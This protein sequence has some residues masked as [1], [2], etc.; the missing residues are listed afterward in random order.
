PYRSFKEP[1]KAYR[2]DVQVAHMRQYVTRND[3]AV[4]YINSGILTKA[5]YETAIRTSTDRAAE[6]WIAA[7]RKL[8]DTVDFTQFAKIL[9]DEAGGDQKSVGEAL[10]VVGL[11][12]AKQ[13]STK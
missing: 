7:L 4:R 10:Q 13:T 11:N 9:S 5:F 1:G 8:K 2:E 6:I 3:T 12:P